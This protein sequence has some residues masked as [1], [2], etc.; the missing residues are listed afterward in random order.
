MADNNGKLKKQEVYIPNDD[1]ISGYDNYAQFYEYDSLNRLSSVR[2][3]KFGCAVNWQQAYT[4]D[5]WGNRTI[6]QT[7]TWG[8]GI[9]KPNFGVDTSTNRLTAPGGYMP[10]MVMVIA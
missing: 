3:N 6:D 8:S 5:L 2:E 7:N 1:Q 4:Y 9:P 10:M